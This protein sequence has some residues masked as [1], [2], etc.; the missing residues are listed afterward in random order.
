MK[1]TLLLA[2]AVLMAAVPVG[3]QTIIGGG[4]GDGG[5]GGSGFTCAVG[6]SGNLIYNNAS[7]CGGAG[8]W[9]GTDLT[10]PLNINSFNSG[11]SASASTFWR[12]DGTWAAPQ[13]APV[14]LGN[15]LQVAYADNTVTGTTT[16]RLVKITGDP[17]KAIILG[18]S[19]TVGLAFGICA[20]GCT[21]SGNATIT[22]QGFAACEFDGSTTALNYVVPS[23]TT[24]GKCH[25]GGSDYPAG[26][27]VL[28]RVQSTNVGAGTYTTT[29]F[30]DD[31]ASVTAGGNGRGTTV[32]INNSNVASNNGNFNDSTPAAPTGA[33]NVLFQKQNGNPSSI[34]A[35]IPAANN[36]RVC[37]MIVGSDNGST[38]ANA[39]LGPQG[40]QCFVQAPATIVEVNVAADAGTPSVLPA[41]NRAGSA[42]NLLS[43]ALA[44]AS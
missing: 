4:A 30:L 8:T 20:S 9:S 22:V 33:T 7:T 24:A 29:L 43:G 32:T 44:T 5:G 18:T 16:N 41:R 36:R 15:S 39:D 13:T 11:T 12:G 23:A 17:P 19:D 31:V 37:A 27:T 26:I 42:T 6:S 1:R 25:D 40:R 3:S 2:L 34:S 28:G 14:S 10:I 21:T 35:Y 38:L